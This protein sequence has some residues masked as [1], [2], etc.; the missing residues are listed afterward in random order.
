MR[1]FNYKALLILIAASFFALTGCFTKATVTDMAPQKTA[2]SFIESCARQEFDKAKEN[3]AGMVLFELE[4]SKENTSKAHIVVKADTSL[5]S[6]GKGF[7]VVNAAL[8]TINPK[9]CEDVH[10]YNLYLIKDGSWKVYK[11]EE[12]DPELGPA[13]AAEE[14]DIREAESVFMDFCSFILQKDY[15]KAGN[16][17]TGRAKNSHEMAQGLLNDIPSVG[18]EA[19]LISSKALLSAKDCLVLQINYKAAGKNLR[20]VVS[21]YRTHKGWRIYNVSQI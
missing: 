6:S 21:C 12:T 1:R 8:E 15:E 17:L 16:C 9:N 5:K 11:I 4:N 7:A 14:K 3:A 2:C 13:V 18:T 19:S 10:W 20:A